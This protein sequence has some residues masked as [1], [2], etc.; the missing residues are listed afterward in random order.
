MPEPAMAVA[1]QHASALC[2][3]THNTLRLRNLAAGELA[4]IRVRM[5]A[6]YPTIL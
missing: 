3:T 1:S 2:N 5:M 4:K 6:I